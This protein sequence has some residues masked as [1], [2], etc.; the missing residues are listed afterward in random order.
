MSQS[1]AATGRSPW[2]M[3]LRLELLPSPHPLL[4]PL[5]EGPTLLGQ[6]QIT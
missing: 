6:T 3:A 1:P 5:S 4:C 2:K